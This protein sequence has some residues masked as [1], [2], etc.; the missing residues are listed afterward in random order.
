MQT[1]QVANK[2]LNEIFA[3][4]PEQKNRTEKRKYSTSTFQ[5]GISI[6]KCRSLHI[7]REGEIFN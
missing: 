6:E 2:R 3:I 4:S 7:V 1:A 5:Q